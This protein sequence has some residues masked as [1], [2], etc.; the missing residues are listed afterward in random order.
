MGW[1]D[2]R[3]A[4]DYWLNGGSWCRVLVSSEQEIEMFCDREAAAAASQLERLTGSS[5]ITASRGDAGDGDDDSIQA[6]AESHGSAK[7]P[8]RA[9]LLAAQYDSGGGAAAADDD[10]DRS[11]A[12]NTSLDKVL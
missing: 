12:T 10:P 6:G 3:G 5:N 2:F 1:N 8:L 11:S 7:N 9:S 4:R